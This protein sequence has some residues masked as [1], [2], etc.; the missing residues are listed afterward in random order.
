MVKN[1]LKFVIDGEDYSISEDRKNITSQKKKYTFEDFGEEKGGTISFIIVPREAA[2]DG[3][4]YGFSTEE[5]LEK[6]LKATNRFDEYKREKE[7]EKRLK[8][9]RTP[10]MLEK[11]KQSQIKEVK[12]TTEKYENFLKQHNLKPEETKKRREILEDYDPFSKFKSHSLYLW[13]NTF[14]PFFRFPWLFIVLPGGHSYCGKRYYRDY[15]DLGIF[16]D[17]NGKGFDNRASSLIVD[18]GSY[19]TLYTDKDLKGAWM[20]FYTNVWTLDFATY[21]FNN[22]FSSARVY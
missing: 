22:S 17:Q 5:K 1:I 14:F 6:W 21:S 10:E 15:P 11:I 2:E 3:T 4:A 8:K 13:D 12:K 9:E 20:R 7:M 19:G 16:K 18:C